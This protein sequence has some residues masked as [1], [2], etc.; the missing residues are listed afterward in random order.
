MR[1][2]EVDVILPVPLYVAPSV[3]DN[4]RE[5]HDVSST[6]STT[7]DKTTTPYA[8]KFLSA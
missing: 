8:R 4:Y 5:R 7:D 1:R 3:A 6:V 2:N